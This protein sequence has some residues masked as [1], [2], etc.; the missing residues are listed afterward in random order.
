MNMKVI[1][2]KFELTLPY[3]P[4]QR[5]LTA[6]R[7]YR[8]ANTNTR[9]LVNLHFGALDQLGTEWQLVLLAKALD[10][11]RDMLPGHGDVNKQAALPTGVR[12]ELSRSLKWL[13]EMSNKRLE[14][15]HVASKG[16]LLPRMSPAERKDFVHDVDLVIRGVVERELGIEAV[17]PPN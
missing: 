11:A 15:R 3:M 7:A 6:V 4:L 12:A 10:L 13:S 5:A 14:T 8:T 17:I 1:P 16:N 9:F 2:G